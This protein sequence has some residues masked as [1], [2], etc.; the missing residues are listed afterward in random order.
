MAELPEAA[1][2]LTTEAACK[3]F[4]VDA[5]KGLSE[6]QV[7]ASREKHGLN[8]L[9]E[10]ETKSLLELILEQFDDL[11]VKILL[12]A[13]VISFG[14]A[15]FE[16]NEE[17]QFTAFVE[18]FVIL[19]IL[20]A[21]AVVGVWQERDAENAIAALK[22]YSPEMAKVIRQGSH[23]V[24]SIEAKMLVP[25]DIVEVAVGDQ[26]PADLR[27]LKINSTVLKIDQSILTGESESVL[28]HADAIQKASVNQD[29]KNMLF[30]GTNVASGKAL[31]LVVSTGQKTEMGRISS[32]LAEDDDRKTPLKIKIEE[33]GEQLCNVIM[34]ICIAVWLINIGHFNDPMHGGSWIKGAIYYFKIAVALAVAAIPEGLPAVITTCLAL[35]TRRMA[36][37]NALVRKLPSVE[38]L[39]CTSV[40][41]SDKTG[42]LT[43]NQMSV[44]DF[45]IIGK[46]KNLVTF[47]VTGDTFAPEGEVT[48][49]GRA[50]NPST[51]KS[52][53]ELAAICSLCNESSV[54]YANGAYNKIGEPTETALIVLVEKLNVTGLNKAGL[55]PEARALACNKDVRSKFQKQMTLEFS[56]DRKSMSALCGTPD[57]PKLY[58]KGAPERI[59]ERCKMVRLDDG[60][61][62]E[63]DN[64]LRAKISAKFLEYGTGS[65]TLRCLGLATVDEPASKSEVEKLAVDPANFVKVETNMTFVGVVGMLDP[66]RQEVKG[67]IAECNGAGIRVI[68]ITGDNKDTAVAIC[69]RIGVFGEKEDVKGKAFTG[70][71]F[72]AMS[73][74][75]QRDAVQHARLFARVEPAHK[76]QIVTHL[77]A[78]HEVSAMTGDGVNDAPALKKADIGVAM[79]SGTAVAKSAAAMILKDDNFATIVSAVEEGRAIYNNT[80]QF[81]RYLISS[82][83]GEVACIFLTAALGLPEALIPVQLLWVNLV[84]DGLPATALSFN[85]PDLDIMQRP[86]R[87]SREPLISRWLFFRYMAIGMYV[88]FATVAA[89]TWWFMFSTEGPQFTWGQLTSF[90]GCTAE[91]W[92]STYLGANKSFLEEGCLTFQDERAMTM[93]LSVLVI[94]ELLNALNSV[95]ED[96][97]LFVMPPWR[98]WLLIAADL[99]SLGLHFMILYVPFLAS[100]FQLQ[101]LNTEEWL[102][103]LY[104]S[105]PVLII[106]EILKLVARMSDRK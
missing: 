84:T 35:G 98:N 39:G 1:W 95:S 9:E 14:L 20:I 48:E 85:P 29:K 104:L 75:Q 60:S 31:G 33:F 88:G 94:I 101:P 67:C 34:Y 87:D 66:P 27:I 46:D 64:A 11:L 45:F 91:N 81:I 50:F 65:K 59:L 61:T 2:L 54:E 13:A 49:N 105:V 106:D 43:T 25:G 62:V 77:Q 22:E 74:A 93:A 51:H 4:G 24:A 18:P 71:E 90:M 47:N 56:R 17:E 57:G 26:V 53:S 36:K 38:T 10:E 79:G 6:A 69:R 103:V 3:H 86:P 52:V 21:N 12:A 100:L 70:A 83:I 28:K 8:E 42:T 55:S 23:G 89:S 97:S 63:L 99:L 41:C 15:F 78:L 72:A 82:N 102:W 96:Q 92:E 44:S 16:D 19:F 68:V 76:S 40:I 32:S 30:S 73:E 5:N 37:K 58:V 7:E 80:K